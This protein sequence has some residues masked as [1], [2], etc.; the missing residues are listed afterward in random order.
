M[1]PVLPAYGR[2]SIADV[3]PALAAHLG[4]PGTSDQWGLP[5]SERYVLLL[6]DGLGRRLLEASAAYAPFLHQHL[7]A[8]RALTSVVPSTTATALT[9]LGTGLPPGE[10]G[11]AGYTFAHPFGTG[12]LNAL[13]WEQGLSGLDVQPRLTQFERLAKAGVAMASVQPAKFAGTGLTISGLRGGSFRPV[14]DE[15]DKARRIEQIVDAATSGA[16]ALVYAYERALDHTGHGSGWQSPAWQAVL[17]WIDSFVADLRSA[18]P[19]DIPLIVTADHGMVDVPRDHRVI[20]EDE[21]TL[22][23]GV[24]LV[25]GEARFRHL[26]T[27]EPDAVAARW[28][29]LL[30]ERAWVRTRAQAVN[31]GWFGWLAPALAARFGDVVV[32]SRDDHAVMTRTFPN[33]LKLVGMHGSLTDAEMAIPLLVV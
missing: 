7:D 17:A 9:S 22:L 28:A 13:S 2:A 25:G 27:A 16:R 4:L 26:Y 29:S 24:R 8:D 12:L 31:E 11:M 1:N 10:H 15:N 6:I 21:P 23:R 30:G 33:E 19:D 5:D 14:T 32:A 18:L 3:V 20:V